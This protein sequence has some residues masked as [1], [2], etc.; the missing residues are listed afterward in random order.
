MPDDD[1]KVRFALSQV[2]SV[3]AFV[4]KVSFDLTPV[5]VK[6]SAKGSLRLLKASK[7]AKGRLRLTFFP[8]RIPTR[9]L[10]LRSRGDADPR[11]GPV[12]QVYGFSTPL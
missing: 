11:T 2:P 1:E 5:A 4:Y 12:R 9:P 8:S 10:P 3:T 7:I 6:G